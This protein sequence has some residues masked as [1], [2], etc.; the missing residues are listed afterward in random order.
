MCTRYS[1]NFSY[2]LEFIGFTRFRRY[3]KPCCKFFSW[4]ADLLEVILECIPLYTLITTLA[5]VRNNVFLTWTLSYY[6]LAFLSKIYN[7]VWK[8]SLFPHI[9]LISHLDHSS[10]STIMWTTKK[11]RSKPVFGYSEYG[12]YKILPNKCLHNLK[13]IQ[14]W[15]G[16]L[17]E[18]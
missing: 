2:T 7:Y 13:N 14:S 5:N 15:V 6:A 17:L 3:T 16:Y 12:S 8:C 11:L 9:Y 10:Q 18:W 4:H 1:L